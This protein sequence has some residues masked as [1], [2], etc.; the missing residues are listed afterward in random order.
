MAVHNSEIAAIFDEVAELLELDGANAFRV[1]AYQN[2]GLTL[3]AMPKS[4]AEMLVRGEDLSE[5]P[6]IGKDLAG[7]IAEIVRSGKLATLEEL[8]ARTPPHIRE[9][10]RS[11]A[12]DQSGYASCAMILASKAWP[13]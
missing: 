7:K 13:T 3:G 12:W 6:G 8:R 4:L 2:A 9:L 10:L 5:L 11:P 1:R